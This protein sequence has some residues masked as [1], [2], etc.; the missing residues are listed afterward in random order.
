VNADLD[1]TV[2][3]A[4]GGRTAFDNLGA[5]CRHHHRLKGEGGWKLDQPRLGVFVWTNPDGHAYR[6]DTNTNDG[7]GV[8][9]GEDRD[10]WSAAAAAAATKTATKAVTRATAAA[11]AEPDP[12]P[13]G[14]RHHT[15][16]CEPCP[17]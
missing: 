12:E 13:M 10:T 2:P 6:N 8:R 7:E 17:F 16:A 9:S 11:G 3:W 5:A 1:H 15:P 4:H 14:L